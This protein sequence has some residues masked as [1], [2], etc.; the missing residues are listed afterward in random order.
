[1]T[2]RYRLA[3]IAL[4]F[5]LL[6]SSLVSAQ[7][8]ALNGDSLAWDQVAS[9]LTEAQGYRYMA[10]LDSAAAAQVTTTC[11]GAAS[12]F[13]C[14]T[15]LSGLATGPHSVR[16]R[17]DQVVGTTVLSSD[18]SALLAFTIA[19]RPGA[20]TNLRILSSSTPS[21]QE[22]VLLRPAVAPRGPQ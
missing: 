19:S 4:V 13:V 5:L 15:V 10:L 18:L 8:L 1:M 12:P 9:S 22:L 6:S 14:R 20:P 21:Q 2:H 11:T 3:S 7:T 16:L 17:T